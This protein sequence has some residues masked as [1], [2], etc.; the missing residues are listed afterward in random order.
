MIYKV[1]NRV[2]QQHNASVDQTGAQRIYGEKGTV[3]ELTVWHKPTTLETA[4]E[5]KLLSM[6]IFIYSQNVVE[7]AESV[8]YVREL[9]FLTNV[10]LHDV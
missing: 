6:R 8:R 5:L 10:D 4:I 1:V 7:L 3:G 2:L 9:G